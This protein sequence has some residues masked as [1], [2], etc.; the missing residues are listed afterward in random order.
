MVD[1]IR[2]KLQVF[3]SSTFSDLIPERQAAVEA[4][5]TAGH[6]PAGMELFTSG[7][8]SQ[9][10]VIKQWIDESDIFLLILG[11][12]YGS[13]EPKNGKSYSQLEYEYAL[14]NRKPL[15]A[16]VVTETAIESRVKSYGT[17]A[18]ETVNAHKLKDFRD[19]VLSKMVKFWEDSKDIKIAIGETLSHFAHREDL[20]GWIRPSQEANMPALANEIVRLSKENATLRQELTKGGIGDSLCGLSF[21]ELKAILE[22]KGLLKFLA[23]NRTNLGSIHGMSMEFVDAV[24]KFVELSTLGLLRVNER[25]HPYH[26]QITDAGRTF[27]NRLEAQ[28]IAHKDLK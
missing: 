1:F 14:N 11:G 4:I 25:I 22:E 9:M 23:E 3:V 15:F 13:V 26:Y 27:L 16:C 8:E 7:D 2:K 28:R 17:C 6:I 19:L 18:I 5:L 20:L 10:D 21:E 12:R 24:P